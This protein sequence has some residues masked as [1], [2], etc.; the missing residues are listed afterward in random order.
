MSTT[1]ALPH[2]H[3][4]SDSGDRILRYSFGERVLHW[5]AGLSYV[6]LLLTGLAF[7]SPYLFW[8]A[9]FFGGG[10]TARFWHPWMGLIFT[11]AVV[12]MYGVWHRDMRA[13]AADR[14]SPGVEARNG[15]PDDP[16]HGVPVGATA[17]AALRPPMGRARGR[18]LTAPTRSRSTRRDIPRWLPV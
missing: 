10:P 6:Y 13:T 16:G 9:M 8:I 3:T 15:G 4:Q 14:D 12:W 17:A 18:A 1:T 11:A 7:W 5:V 2:T